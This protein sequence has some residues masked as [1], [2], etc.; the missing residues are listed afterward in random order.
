VLEPEVFKLK[1]SRD[2]KIAEDQ[3]KIFST[4]FH[5]DRRPSVKRNGYEAQQQYF[6]EIELLNFDIF[7]IH[8]SYRQDEGLMDGFALELSGEPHQK[9]CN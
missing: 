1:I 5:S 6:E 8:S 3:I 2:A 4:I 7:F 9:V